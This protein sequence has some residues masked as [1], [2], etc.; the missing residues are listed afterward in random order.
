MKTKV[1]I[2]LLLI[3]VFMLSQGCIALHYGTMQNSAALSSNNFSYVKKDLYGTARAQ[4]ILFIGG[5][6]REAL[7]NEAKQNMLA[8]NPL[9]DN[10]ALANITVNFKSSSILFFYGELKCTVTAD[11]V[12]FK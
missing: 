6:K 4:Y 2:S 5:Y 1:T 8:I 11:I 10:Q 7:V 12:E 9:E 3:A